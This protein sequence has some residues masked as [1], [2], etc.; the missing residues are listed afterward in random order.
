ML[1]LVL[2]NCAP[3]ESAALADD[4]VDRDLAACVN[5]FAGVQSHYEWEGESRRDEEATLL[6]KTTDDRYEELKSWLRE[7]HSYD[8]PEI[9][10]LEAAD[11][12]EAYLQWVDRQTD[13][14]RE[15]N[16]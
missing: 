4:L 2:C 13:P 15:S 7:A 14:V 1:K 16:Q 11:V 10:A 9:I 5:V 8:V 6:I 3:R 12:E